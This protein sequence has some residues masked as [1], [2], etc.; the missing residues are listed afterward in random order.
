VIDTLKRDRRAAEDPKAT[1][2]GSRSILGL[3]GRDSACCEVGAASTGSL[4]YPTAEI[5]SSRVLP[6]RPIKAT[7]KTAVPRRARL[8]GS[9]VAFGVTVS[10]CRSTCAPLLVV[11]SVT[12]KRKSLVGLV[13]MLPKLVVSPSLAARVLS[14]ASP[15]KMPSSSPAVVEFSPIVNELKFDTRLA[16][17]SRT[18]SLPLASI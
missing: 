16:M 6:R 7:A 17:S 12:K 8:V 11:L 13:N 18:A 14:V 5:I 4:V 15:A 9:G 3:L 1:R 10:D 2:V